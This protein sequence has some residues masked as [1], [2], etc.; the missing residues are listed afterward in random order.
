AGFNLPTAQRLFGK[1][2]K[3]DQIRAAAK[4]GISDQRLV[5]Q[6]KTI[7]PPHTQVRTG[8]GQAKEDSKDSESFISFLQT[9]LLAFAGIALLVGAFVI[10]NSFSITIAQRTREFA[11][12]RPLG[13]SRNQVLRSIAVESLVT[14]ALASVVGLFLGFGLAK[15]LFKL[16]DAVGFTLP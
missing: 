7:L 4:P 5:D 13:A 16:F 1:E 14:G 12:L 10:A 9:F 3:L 2:G 8:T 6:I 15:L 11:T